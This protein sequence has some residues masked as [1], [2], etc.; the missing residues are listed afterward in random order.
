MNCTR[1]HDVGVIKSSEVAS[2]VAVSGRKV[3]NLWMYGFIGALT[4]VYS[5]GGSMT[6]RRSRL[7][8]GHW[9]GYL[10]SVA[11]LAFL[12]AAGHAA[13]IVSVATAGAQDTGEETVM[14]V[15]SL[16]TEIDRCPF[17]G[18]FPV[19]IALESPLHLRW[20]IE[21]KLNID[22]VRGLTAT[23]YV[24]DRQ[25]AD[26][27][28]DGFSVRAIPNQARR[29]YLEMLRHPEREDYHTY[30]SLSTELQQIA[31]DHP[32]ITMLSSIGLSVEGRELWMMKISDNVGVDEPEPEFKYTS[33]MH[34]DEPVGTEMCVYLIRLL[35]EGYG[36]DPELTALVDD[37][38][39]WICPLHN[40]DGFVHGT[41]SN[42]NG[43]DLNRNFPDPV[44][45]PYDDPTG[46]PVE[47]QHMMY[48]QYDHNFILGANFH[49]G[50]VVVNYPWDSMYGEYTPDHAMIHNLA[51]GYAFRN[52]PMWNS[53]Y[54]PQGVIIGWEWYVIHGGMQDWAY[55]WRNEVHYTIEL[56]D[57]KW[58]P[59]S[60]LP[61]FWEDN[62]EAMLWL[63]NQARIGVEGYVTD[64]SA[65]TPLKAIIDVEEIG[66]SI[67][68]EP[69][70]GYYHRLLEPGTYTLEFSAFGYQPHT[71]NGVVVSDGNTTLLDV[72]LT[73]TAR[74]TVSGVV[75]EEGTGL[76]L[77][78]QV[79]AYR[80][81]NGELFQTVDSDPLTGGYEMEV[82]AWEYDFV[83][84]ADDH[85][86]STETREITCNTTI[87]FS[88]LQSRGDV[89]LV[90]DNNPN[91]NMVPDLVTLGYLVTE[92]TIGTTNPSTWSDYDLLVWSA[93]SYK[94]PVAIAG[95]RD[96]LEA[97]VAAGGKLLIEG[98][99]LGYDAASNPGY[100]SFAAHV[101][102]V[103]EWDADSAGDLPLRPEQS[104]HALATSPNALPSTIDLTYDYFGDQDAV[105]PLA[106]AT[107]IYGTESHPADAGILVYDDPGTHEGQIVFYAF[108]YAAL[109]APLV[110]MD[111]LENT[112]EY[113]VTSAQSVVVQ[114]VRSIRLSQPHPSVTRGPVILQLVLPEADRA[115]L[116]VYDASGRH[117]RTL[118]K[119]E[120]DAGFH[121]IAWDGCDQAGRRTTAGVYFLKASASAGEASR[122]LIIVD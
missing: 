21:R 97:Y 120:I 28:R 121:L 9:L 81:D 38:E 23:A 75:T 105:V 29:A 66:K 90:V 116:D 50:A 88:L 106:D 60:Q 86:S 72:Q 6:H 67:W 74:Y 102:H 104:G 117:V 78:A 58:P 46:R 61:G 73:P 51:L 108:D 112:L 79:A 91:P 69:I 96:G 39:I 57:I 94:N 71:E 100:P 107:L 4:R 122:R 26:L 15:E 16:P 99:E 43:F 33:T 115:S 63:L 119:G 101:L 17:T 37:L 76:P 64:A 62:R 55:N 118:L 89:L 85:V 24:D 7:D 84:S 53:P 56:S 109:T 68:G 54:F 18:R 30:E 113:L 42:A 77:D 27:Q 25:F 44:T 1:A 59:G 13:P 45:D 22:D 3:I 31:T 14:P 41:R 111:L 70:D 2:T 52:P 87:D 49:T 98:G 95:L 80:H 20:L 5:G 93:G 12:F 110:A 36:T 8:Q 103:S 19:E 82:P 35:V 65:G 114:E 34:G 40:P 92:E 47:V 11:A 10:R 83:A 32:D 48:F